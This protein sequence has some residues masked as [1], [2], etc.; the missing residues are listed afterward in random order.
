MLP[1][2]SVKLDLSIIRFPATFISANEFLQFIL[3]KL[4]SLIVTLSPLESLLEA[5]IGACPVEL[6]FS[7]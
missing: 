7:K 1:A 5:R 2:M 6:M 3:L 4:E